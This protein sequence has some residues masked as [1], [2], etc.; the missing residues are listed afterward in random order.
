MRNNSSNTENKTSIENRNVTNK[1]EK[2]QSISL[3]APIS[4]NQQL[5]EI[6]PGMEKPNIPNSVIILKKLFVASLELYMLN[7]TFISLIFLL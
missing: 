2:E 3:N 4:I 1:S 7:F 5:P 6:P